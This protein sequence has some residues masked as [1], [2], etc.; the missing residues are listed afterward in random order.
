[1]NA[2]VINAGINGDTS[3]GRSVKQKPTVGGF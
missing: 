1:V 2:R 3:G